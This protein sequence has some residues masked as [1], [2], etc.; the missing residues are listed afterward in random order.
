VAPEM[1]AA[2]SGQNQMLSW[3]IYSETDARLAAPEKTAAKAASP[4]EN[5][6]TP[7]DFSKLQSRL[8]WHYAFQNSTKEPAKTSVSALRRRSEADDDA[9]LLFEFRGKPRS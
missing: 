2:T 5:E 8:V 3:T 9:R 6:V 1:A 7:E 4:N